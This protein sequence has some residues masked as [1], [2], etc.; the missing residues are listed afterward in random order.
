MNAP[1]SK[2]IKKLVEKNI[3]KW[4][5]KTM[6]EDNLNPQPILKW[7]NLPV[8][9][10]ILRYKM[11]WNGYLNY[12]SFTNNKPKLILIY[13]I[14][15]KSLAKTLA[16]K[17]NLK[18]VRKV[19]LKFGI[20]ISFR[21]PNT[22]R[23]IDFSKPD[24]LPTP[25]DFKGNTN[26]NEVLSVVDWNLR[27]INFFNYVCASCGS[28]ENL[29]VHHLKHIKTINVNLNGFDKQI[30]A[31]NRKQITLCSKCHHSVH[32]GNYDGMSLKHLKEIRK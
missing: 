20:N 9:D 10:I 14:L 12:Y 3:V 21:I 32:T 28:N 4:S 31:I 29:Q 22:D 7:M 26:F 15:R 24:L 30:A 25:I 27:T 5:S 17:L 11:I 13:W 18:T 1:I 19:Y 23:V 6:S 2:L 16:A 8:R